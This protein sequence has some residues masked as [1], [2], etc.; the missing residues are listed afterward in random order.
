L[1]LICKKYYTRGRNFKRNA[2]RIPR[3]FKEWKQNYIKKMIKM[4]KCKSTENSD[5]S[6]ESSSESSEMDEGEEIA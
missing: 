1:Y 2:H 3:R 4:I 5:E 6:Y